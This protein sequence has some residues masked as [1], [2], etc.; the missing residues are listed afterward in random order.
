MK[1]GQAEYGASKFGPD[2]TRVASSSARQ[3]AFAANTSANVPTFYERQPELVATTLSQPETRERE[4]LESYLKSPFQTPFERRADGSRKYE[5]TDYGELVGAFAELAEGMR[6]VFEETLRAHYVDWAIHNE[7]D[8]IGNFVGIYRQT[9]EKDPAYRLR[10]KAGFRALISG[11]SLGEVIRITAMLLGVTPGN[12][13]AWEPFVDDSARIV[14]EIPNSV[15]EEA[16]IT[17]EGMVELILMY[18]AAG[19]EISVTGDDFFTHRS[20]E[21]VRSG[22]DLGEKGYNEA[23]YA[24]RIN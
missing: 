24:G 2:E 5:E 12:V 10:I 3:V 13:D 8:E 22:T 18:R 19:V 23:P 11:A 7:L 4:R 16:D 15:L 9:G 1:Y 14:L 20:I 17:P 6:Y 21:D